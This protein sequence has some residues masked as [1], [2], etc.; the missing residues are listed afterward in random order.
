MNDLVD[1]DVAGLGYLLF[2]LSDFRPTRNNGEHLNYKVT[3][4]FYTSDAC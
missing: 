3:L 4:L 2:T 1:V